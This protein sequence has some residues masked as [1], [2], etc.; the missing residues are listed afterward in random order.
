MVLSPKSDQI[1]YGV[2]ADV[3]VVQIE[4]VGLSF[5]SCDRA[6]AIEDY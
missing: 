5:K 6:F 3:G 2:S 1:T 4:K